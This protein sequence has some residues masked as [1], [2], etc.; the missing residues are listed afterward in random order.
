VRERAENNGKAGLSRVTDRRRLEVHTLRKQEKKVGSSGEK[1]RGR[2]NMK[3]GAGTP[4]VD[5]GSNKGRRGLT[6]GEGKVKVSHR[7]KGK[8]RKL[9]SLWDCEVRGK[10]YERKFDLSAQSPS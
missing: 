10:E 1:E 2:E 5:R 8:E 3:E 6:S 4:L 9:T 7:D